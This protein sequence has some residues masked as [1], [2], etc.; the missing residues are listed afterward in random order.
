MQIMII[1]V[2]LG[3]FLFST[4][5]D[6]T[7]KEAMEVKVFNPNYKASDEQMLALLKRVNLTGHGYKKE[8]TRKVISK[9][10]SDKQLFE[11]SELYYKVVNCS[12]LREIDQELEN[13]LP[14]VFGRDL[15]KKINRE[16]KSK[17]LTSMKQCK[18]GLEVHFKES[19]GCRDNQRK[20]RRRKR[21]CSWCLMCWNA[22]LSS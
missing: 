6:A 13:L 11:K 7:A 3:L 15:V 14:D 9:P 4:A 1:S 19:E 21:G 18:V 20:T 22:H 16:I 10:G 2:L 5:V 12:Q 8:E 17:N